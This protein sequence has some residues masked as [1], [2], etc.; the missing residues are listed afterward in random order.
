MTTLDKFTQRLAELDRDLQA[1]KQNID[2]F[3]NGL[4]QHTNNFQI[5][6]GARA[7]VL[8]WL[9]KLKEGVEVAEVVADAACEVCDTIKE[10]AE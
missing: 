10:V 8:N 5:L 9:N 4:N 7:E 1:T 6:S 2:L 3:Q